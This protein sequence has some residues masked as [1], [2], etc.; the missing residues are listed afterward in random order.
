VSLPEP[1]ADADNIEF[2]ITPGASVTEDDAALF[3]VTRYA[4][5]LAYCHTEGVWR[6]FDGSIWRRCELPT[7][8]AYARQLVRRLSAT[9]K[10]PSNLKKL[11]FMD[12]VAVLA[13]RDERISRTAANWDQDP[14]LLGTP[15]GTVELKTGKLRSPRASDYITRSTAVAP[16]KWAECPLWLEF[17]KQATAGDEDLIRFLQQ[18]AGYALTGSTR[19]Q[20]LFFIYGPGGNGKGIYVNTISA[21]LGA[22]ATTAVMNTFTASKND[23]HT[24]DLAMLRGARLVTASETSQGARWDQQRIAALTGEDMITARFMRQDNFTFRPEFTLIIVGNYKPSL[25]S[26][27]D[28]MRRRFNIIPFEHRPATPD[29][30]LFEKLRPEWPG[31][32][33]WMIEGCLDWQADGMQRAQSVVSRTEQYFYDEDTVKQWLEDECTVGGPTLM[34]QS[35]ALFRSWVSF[36]KRNEE[37]AGNAKQFKAMMEKAGFTFKRQTAGVMA[38]GVELKHHDGDGLDY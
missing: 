22:Y 21:I 38:Y 3:F 25:S 33:K 34:E 20:S 4:D 32:L 15:A 28:A 12:N 10:T 16:D 6:E 29:R 13:S 27:D 31:I 14:W 7:A 17:M 30:D 26:V 2:L 18:I 9:A 19:E 36:C 5:Q 35:S 11:R 8:F 1:P 23:K 24:T 37:W